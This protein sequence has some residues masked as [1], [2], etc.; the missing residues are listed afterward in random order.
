MLVIQSRNISDLQRSFRTAG[1][2]VAFGK[3][4]PLWGF[5][6]GAWEEVYPIF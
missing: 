5:D 2:V 1:L 3:S 4:R 6:H